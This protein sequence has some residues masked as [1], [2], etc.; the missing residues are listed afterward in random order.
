MNELHCK[1]K[2]RPIEDVI[3]RILE[4]RALANTLAQLPKDKRMKFL[5]AYYAK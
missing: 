2:N 3:M 1:F 5:R 4:K